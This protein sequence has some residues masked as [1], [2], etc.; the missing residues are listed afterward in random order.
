M[1]TKT[2]HSSRAAVASALAAALRA[3][4][5]NHVTD[6]MVLEVL[7]AWLKGSRGVLLPHGI[8]G[9]TVAAQFD[10]LEA[11]QPGALRSLR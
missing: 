7:Q 8:V 2:P 1:P 9:M 4:G 10:A 5:F 11:E 6:A 3:E